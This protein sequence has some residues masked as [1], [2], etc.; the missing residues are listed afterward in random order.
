MYDLKE[1]WFACHCRDRAS[2]R[3]RPGCYL[4]G[5][6]FADYNVRGSVVW[7]LR[8]RV[9]AARVGIKARGRR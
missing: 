8:G 5:S 3:W 1:E 4:E 9:V 2:I 6:G 7:R